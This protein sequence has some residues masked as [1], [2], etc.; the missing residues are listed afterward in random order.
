[1]NKKYTNI[2]EVNATKHVY[3]LDIIFEKF[4]YKKSCGIFCKEISVKIKNGKD[5]VI[6]RLYSVFYFK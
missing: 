5:I 3:G 4:C 2:R 6:T 1:M